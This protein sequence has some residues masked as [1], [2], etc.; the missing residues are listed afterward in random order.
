M[1]S[2]TVKKLEKHVL[3]EKVCELQRQICEYER[4]CGDLLIMLSKGEPQ[5]VV[6]HEGVWEGAWIWE[7]VHELLR[8]NKELAQKLKAYEEKQ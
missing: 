6:V 5:C 8:E 7:K 4:Y 1:K 2:R 3:T